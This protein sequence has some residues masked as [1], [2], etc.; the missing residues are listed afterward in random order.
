MRTFQTALLWGLVV[1][2]LVSWVALW[3]TAHIVG[4][5]VHILLVIAIAVTIVNLVN[6]KDSHAPPGKGGSQPGG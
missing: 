5:L 6:R 1:V 2:L 4:A 3:L